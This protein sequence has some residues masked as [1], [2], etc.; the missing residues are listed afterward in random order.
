MAA[1]RLAKSIMEQFAGMSAECYLPL[2]FGELEI[3]DRYIGIPLPGDNS[4]HGGFRGTYNVFKKIRRDFNPDRP[5]AL[6]ISDRVKT[7]NPAEM[8]VIKLR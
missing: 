3:G 5:N 2:T 6:R 8:A 4:G 1:T 7:Y